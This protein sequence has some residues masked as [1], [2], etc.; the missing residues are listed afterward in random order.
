MYREARVYELA[1]LW[2]LGSAA[3]YPRHLH[4]TILLATAAAPPAKRPCHTGGRASV[5]KNLQT[6]YALLQPVH[7]WGWFEDGR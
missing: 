5:I 6:V 1:G 7:M 3:G 2:K 4:V